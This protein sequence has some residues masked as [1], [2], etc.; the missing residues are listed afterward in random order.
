MIA[1]IVLAIVIG[2]FCGD[3]KNH[4][5]AFRNQSPMLFCQRA[6]QRKF[7]PLHR[8][9]DAAQGMSAQRHFVRCKNQAKL[10][11]LSI[12]LEFGEGELIERQQQTL[13]S[14]QFDF[15]CA[16]VRVAR[17]TFGC[18]CA[19]GFQGVDDDDEKV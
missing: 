18:F 11:L 10:L 12:A 3:F 15:D 16:S 8:G 14:R 17:P 2:L 1:L 5:L 13:L 7:H 4:W 19:H 6:E 9:L